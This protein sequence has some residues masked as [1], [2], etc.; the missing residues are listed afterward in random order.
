[1]SQYI[2]KLNSRGQYWDGIQFAAACKASAA[3]LSYAQAE[4][5]VRQASVYGATV[6]IEGAPRPKSWGVFY[7]RPQDIVNGAVRANFNNP[8]KHRFATEDEA[9]V[10]GAR[11]KDRCKRGTDVKLGHRGHYVDLVDGEPTSYIGY[12]GLTYAI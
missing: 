10:H 11:A 7:I 5:I 9:H 3:K 6:L 4:A 8:S 2:V 1:M 12:D